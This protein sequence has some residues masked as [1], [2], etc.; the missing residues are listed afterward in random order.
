MVNIFKRKTSKAEDM[1]EEMKRRMSQKQRILRLFQEKHQVTN[2]DL[3]RI[4]YRYSARIG[5]L[6]KEY[7]IPSPKY[8]KP[9]VF[10]YTYKG[11]K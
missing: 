6:R 8:I 4:S 10:L 1:R 7:K 9:G 11:E 3:A 2:L 5:D